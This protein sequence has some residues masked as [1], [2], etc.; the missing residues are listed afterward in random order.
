MKQI[1][2]WGAEE[3]RTV[4]FVGGSNHNLLRGVVDRDLIRV[5]R[6]RQIANA[7]LKLVRRVFATAGRTMMLHNESTQHIR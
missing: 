4:L 1:K 6:I 2:N 5:D 7:P 3:W